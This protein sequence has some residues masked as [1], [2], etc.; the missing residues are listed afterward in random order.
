MHVAENFLVGAGHE[1][2][3]QQRFIRMMFRQGQGGFDALAIHILVNTA[4]GI[5]GDVLDDSAAAKGPVQAVDRHDRED[6]VNAPYVRKGLEQGEVYE[7]FF[8]QFF[9]QFVDDFPVGTVG[10]VQLA[11]QQ[12][13]ATGVQGFC[14]RSFLQ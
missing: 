12:A 14:L 8:G 11:A 3:H 5:A 13:A 10:T 4:V 6:L 9:V 1:K 7:Q 2:A